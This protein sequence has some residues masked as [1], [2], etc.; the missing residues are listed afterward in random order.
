[1]KGLAYKT[2]PVCRRCRPPICGQEERGTTI[3]CFKDGH[4]QSKRVPHVLVPGLSASLMEVRLRKSVDHPRHAGLQMWEGRAEAMTIES[5]Q[6]AGGHA[7]HCSLH[8][9]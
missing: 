7:T 3:L 2:Q 8:V 5:K 6:P 4:W 9:T 1:M